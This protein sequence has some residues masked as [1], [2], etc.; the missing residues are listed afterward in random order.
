MSN[1]VRHLRLVPALVESTDK[2]VAARQILPEVTA[3]F[4]RTEFGL[5]YEPAPVTPT[6]APAVAMPAASLD[7]PI[8][9]VSYF[10]LKSRDFTCR[11][12][13]TEG[14]VNKNANAEVIPGK[15][16]RIFGLDTNRY[17]GPVAYDYTFKVGEVAEYD[18][19]NLH[20]FEIIT[21]ITPKRVKFNNGRALDIE[22][23]SSHND[24]D[25]EAKRKSNYNW[26]D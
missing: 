12:V 13:K 15:S 20:Y 7:L 18:S 6:T 3:E 14:S 5:D 1:A 11:G 9:A 25:M 26:M 16:I 8:G 21:S 17:D 22:R 23:F 24:D 4:M 10:G 19:Y 2:P